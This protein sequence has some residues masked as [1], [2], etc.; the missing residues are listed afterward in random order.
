MNDER[1]CFNVLST[2][3]TKLASLE[4]IAACWQHATD[5]LSLDRWL[6]EESVILL[7]DAAPVFF[8]SIE[9]INQAIF[10]CLAHLVLRQQE[11]ATRRTWIIL[12]EVS[13]AGRIES[14]PALM[15]Q[16]RAKGVCVAFGMQKL[17]D[18]RKLYGSEGAEDLLTACSHK[19]VLRTDDPET[20]T[21]AQQLFGLETRGSD[22]VLRPPM[23]ATEFMS[24]PMA[25]PKDGLTGFHQTPRAGAYV[26]HK[27]WDWVLAHLAPPKDAAPGQSLRPESEHHLQDWTDEDY[28]RL[29]LDNPPPTGSKPSSE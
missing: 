27:S 28:R 1:M 16:R 25:G 4:V 14:L 29:G 22:F 19:T 8:K 13:E 3:A 17:G 9:L 10:G 26:A 6:Q 21:W 18:L 23:L 24:L 15:R 7:G 11:S 12:D 5:K 2:L 20:A